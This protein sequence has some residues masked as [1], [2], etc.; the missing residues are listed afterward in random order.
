MGLR[1]V[2]VRKRR[3]ALTWAIVW[4]LLV[5]FSSGCAKATPTPEPVTI[6]FAYPS[7]LSPDEAY[8][9]ALVQAF[10]QS[11]PHISIE[12]LPKSWE[13]MGHL[14]EGKADF[15]EVDVFV[16][17]LFGLGGLQERGDILNL[18]PW[19]AQDDSFDLADF[20]AGALELFTSG[21]STWAIPMEV[22]PLVMFYSRDLFDAYKV[23]YPQIGWT[24]DDFLTTAQALRDS[25][26][27]VFGYAIANKYADILSFIY[28]H[29]GRI[30]DDWHD[31]ACTTYDDP[32]T[33]EALE[34]LARLIHE[35]DAAPT[36]YQAAMAFGGSW[37][38]V[39]LGI[40]YAKVGMWIGH[41]G[42]REGLLWPP[43]TQWT[44]N[45]GVV[46]LPRDVHAATQV[47]VEALAISSQAQHPDACWHWIAFLSEQIPYVSTPARRSVA[48][49]SA[50]EEQ[51]GADP[52]AAVRAALSDGLMFSSKKAYPRFTEAEEAFWLAIDDIIKGDSTPEEAMRRAQEQAKK[53]E[54]K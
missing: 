33:I 10:H 41:F 18:D 17:Q 48:E 9:Q 4:T 43:G 16:L 19:I 6:R 21:G 11:Y 49:S 15:G 28:Q 25:E 53:Q 46:P 40:R 27:N 29:G 37:A 44:F 34:W 22:D 14:M 39:Y 3:L 1:D 13:E 50:Y 23:S 36:P 35:Y 42:E 52:A 20:Y 54:P 12:L 24:W 5:L 7:Q 2:R 51:V 38:H 31:P 8:N 47:R 30:F 26:A 32:L 45:W